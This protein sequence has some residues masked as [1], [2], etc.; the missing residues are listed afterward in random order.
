M[1]ALPKDVDNLVQGVQT[2]GFSEGFIY[3]NSLIYDLWLNCAD[4]YGLGLGFGL[5]ASA[6]IARG[7]FV[8]V[9]IYGVRK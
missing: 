9:I 1:S 7:M 3:Y 5:I 4:F 2:Y 6:L 8:P